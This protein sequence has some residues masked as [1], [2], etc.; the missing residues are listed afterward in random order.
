MPSASDTSCGGKVSV[1]GRPSPAE[2]VED[3]HEANFK[4]RPVSRRDEP[5]H[6]R[7]VWR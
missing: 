5:S 2:E 3:G 7:F 1:G 6:S 4:G